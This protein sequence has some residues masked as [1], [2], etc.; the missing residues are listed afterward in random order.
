MANSRP[1]CVLKVPRLL[2]QMCLLDIPL[3]PDI[4]G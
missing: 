2:Y 1:D 4:R 3:T